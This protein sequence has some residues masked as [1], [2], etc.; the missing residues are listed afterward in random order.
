[1]NEQKFWEIRSE[2]YN[3]L[4]W[5]N[6]Q[7]YLDSL[8]AAGE[9]KK[10]D[11]VLDVGTGT[12]IIAHAIAPLVKEVIGLDISQDMLEHSN[13]NGNKY[14]IRRDIRD[15]IFSENVFDKVTARMVFH[16]IIKD[17]QKAMNECHKILKTGGRMVLAEG[18]PPTKEVKDDYIKIFRLKEER[19][20]FYEEDLELL[21]TQAGFK[22]VKTD[23]VWLKKMS[24][25]NWLN[26]SGLPQTTQDKIFKLH[27]HASQYFKDA[28]NMLEVDGDCLIDMKMAIVAG[29]KQL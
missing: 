6:R 3:E 15:P 25:K 5:A 20:T 21:M 24:V 9:F 1:M 4:E 23:L 13:W 14:F 28:Y 26:K 18:V 19:L 8:L 17:T 22:N 10:S 16:H 29:V 12:G 11:L 7:T 2:H 27:S